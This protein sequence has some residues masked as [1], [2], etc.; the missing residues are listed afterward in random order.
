MNPWGNLTI[1]QETRWSD[2]CEIDALIRNLPGVG[3]FQLFQGD[4]NDV[5]I[6]GVAAPTVLVN[7]DVKSNLESINATGIE[8][9]PVDYK[10]L[11]DWFWLLTTSFIAVDV[12]SILGEKQKVCPIT[13]RIKGNIS[14]SEKKVKSLVVTDNNEGCDFVKIGNLGMGFGFCSERVVELAQ[15]KKWRNWRAGLASNQPMSQW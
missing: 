4:L 3:K 7:S 14:I 8:F 12:D 1:P 2:L 11:R 6:C 5:D 15:E 9:C 13:K 10:G